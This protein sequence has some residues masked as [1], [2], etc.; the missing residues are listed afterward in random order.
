[1]LALDGLGASV[2][3]EDLEDLAVLVDL[4]LVVLALVVLVLVVLGL[5]LAVP[6]VLVLL[7]RLPV[8]AFGGR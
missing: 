4:A 8:A 2:G 3:L 5:A 7:A 6:V 1:M